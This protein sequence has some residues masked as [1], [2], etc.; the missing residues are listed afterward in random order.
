VLAW[1]DR[2]SAVGA[3]KGTFGIKCNCRLQAG[4]TRLKL[5]REWE[6]EEEGMTRKFPGYGVVWVLLLCWAG[7]EGECD[8][9]ASQLGGGWR[10][11]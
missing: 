3:E 2:D 11:R 5:A 1:S 7:E 10:G 4:S 8:A 6:E 9:G